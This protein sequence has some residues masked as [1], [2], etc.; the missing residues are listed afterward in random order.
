M[1][2]ENQMSWASQNVISSLD[3]RINVEWNWLHEE[4]ANV[5]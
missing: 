2:Q 3:D 1:V 5:M 4:E